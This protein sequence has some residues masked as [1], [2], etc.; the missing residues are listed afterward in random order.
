MSAW[1]DKLRQA[2]DAAPRPVAFFFRDDDAGWD[3]DRL[4]ELL[5]LFARHAMPVDVAAIP[6]ALTSRM[7]AELRARIEAEPE[8]LAVHQHGFAHRNHEPE[9]R[10]K[11][12]FG[13]AR[14]QAL[15][16]SD[17]EQGKRRL[18]DL[19][20]SR[21]SPIFTP[22]WNRCER[23]TGECLLRTGLRILSR[24][25]SAAP[26]NLDGLFELP[27]TIDWF[28]RARGVRLSL[29]ELGARMASAVVTSPAPVGIMFHHAL[30]DET[31]RERSGELL[32]LLASHR[33][34]QR[35]LMEQLV[36]SLSQD[37]A[38]QVGH[39]QTSGWPQFAMPALAT[40][41]RK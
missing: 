5:D 14:G 31:E 21:L 27:V 10:R 37:M 6:D 33:N 36:T 18:A 16:Q 4:L 34:A 15:Q 13:S 39:G 7:A 19:F 30:M 8:R 24:D 12:E 9:G 23:V 25:G 28:A 41:E 3:D 38:A 26:L 40:A 32:A 20:G 29:D 11:C 17:I 35:C 1:L 2:L 22:P